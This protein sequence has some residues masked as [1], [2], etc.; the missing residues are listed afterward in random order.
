MNSPFRYEKLESAQTAGIV[1]QV[2]T[3]YVKTDNGGLQ[4]I[5]VTRKFFCDDY[6]DTMTT[7]ILL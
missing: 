4:K 2:L 5:T 6:T 3:T 7:E 1:K